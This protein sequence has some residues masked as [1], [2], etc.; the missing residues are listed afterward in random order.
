[1][2]DETLPGRRMS[3]VEYMVGFERLDAIRTELINVATGTVVPRH[4]A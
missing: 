2:V 4:D 3:S 1:L